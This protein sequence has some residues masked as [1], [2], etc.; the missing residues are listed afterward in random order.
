MFK[1]KHHTRS[2]TRENECVFKASARSQWDLQ[3]W[4]FIHSLDVRERDCEHK[5]VERP[6]T[7]Q[8]ENISGY[9][10]TEQTNILSAFV[11][12]QTHIKTICKKCNT[13]NFHSLITRLLAY[14]KCFPPLNAFVCFPLPMPRNVLSPPLTAAARKKRRRYKQN[15]VE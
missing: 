7:R 11:F 15:K 4:S 5:Q 14:K 12:A 2:T 13:T 9:Y 3:R 10:L 6:Q 8:R 1:N